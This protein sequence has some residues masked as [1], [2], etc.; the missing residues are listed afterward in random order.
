MELSYDTIREILDNMLEDGYYD[1]AM[2]YGE[3]GYDFPAGATTPMVVLGNYWCN[4]H[5]VTN[6]EGNEQLHGHER[7]HP[8]IW[9]QMMSQGVQFEWYDE[10]VTDNNKAYRTQSD[11]YSWRSSIQITEDG[12]ILTP[13]DD[14][15]EWIDW[16][17]ND[18]ERC[19]TAPHIKADDMVNA[20]FQQYNGEFQNGWHYG[21]DAD[22]EKITK[23]IRAKRGD[24]VDIVYRLSEAS[25]FYIGF[26][27][28]LKEND[29]DE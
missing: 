16:A 9:A 14:I 7:H 13:D 5:K 20:D 11:S 28:W 17:K 2:E 19:I 23:E 27:C 4:C 26:E 3:P 24:S 15:S 29:D 6:A 25:Q 18:H 10:W 12:E 1:A 21:M 8:R 22:P